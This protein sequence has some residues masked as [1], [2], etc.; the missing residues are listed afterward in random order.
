[1]DKKLYEAVKT[2]KEYCAGRNTRTG[3]AFDAEPDEDGYIGC[4]DCNPSEWKINHL[5]KEVE[6]NG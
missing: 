6:D 4:F 3:C 1:M 2:V 5:E